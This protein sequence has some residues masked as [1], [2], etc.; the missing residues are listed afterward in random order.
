M[1]RLDQDLEQL[2]VRYTTQRVIEA[3]AKRCHVQANF[4][5]TQ[6]AG[7]KLAARWFAKVA[8]ALDAVA[9]IE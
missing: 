8:K 1:T 7:G 9:R 2:C 3:L 5:N 6:G 4:Q